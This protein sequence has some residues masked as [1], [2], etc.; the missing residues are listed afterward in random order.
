M[1]KNDKPIM[2]WLPW[3]LVVVLA[4][5][6]AAMLALGRGAGGEVAAT[7]VGGSTTTI[8]TVP[9]DAP[10]VTTTA[11]PS[12][13]TA[14]AVTT[15]ATAVTTTLPA[16]TTT[17]VAV[18][19]TLPAVTTTSAVSETVILTE[20]GI[21][22]A[23]EWIPF[24]ANDDDTIAAVTDVLGQPTGDFGWESVVL[25]PSPL[26][27]LQWG[28]FVLMFTK[29]ESDFWTAGV[30][31]FIAFEYTGTSPLLATDKGITVGSSVEMLEDAYS[32]PDFRL[33]E[34]PYVS[35]EGFW[36]YKSKGWTGLSGFTTGL[37]GAHAVIS[38]S[39]GRG[40][41]E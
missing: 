26:R 34:S 16:V 23:G 9:T 22:V 12:T 29:A 35:S 33:E 3:M 27:T 7:T 25:C 30:P 4:A 40:C 19:T 6:I 41:S 8:G 5:I 24:G 32:G 37:L 1:D 21:E 39:G 31:H 36:T 11:A 14:T 20:E 10:A 17:A 28:D 13:T 2:K 38:I 18:T 15:T